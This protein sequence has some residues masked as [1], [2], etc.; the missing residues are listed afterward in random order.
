MA[1]ARRRS[2]QSTASQHDRVTV[3]F[4]PDGHGF[5]LSGCAPAAPPTGRAGRPP[6]PGP[7][8][9]WTW[10]GHKKEDTMVRM[11]TAVLLVL[12][13]GAGTLA[14]QS[15]AAAKQATATEV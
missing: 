1:A 13:L 8:R 2:P 11:I 14:A 9:R 10:H 3:P 12:T 6:L 7:P 5:A 4:L 15:A